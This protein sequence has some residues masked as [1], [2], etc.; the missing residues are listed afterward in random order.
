LSNSSQK[1]LG[2]LTVTCLVVGGM[3]G[4]G[5][6]TL[7]SALAQ[8]GG[9][10]LTGW[11]IAAAGAL[12]LAKMFGQLSK[13]IP[14]TGGAY[15]YSREAFGEF[16]GFIV[17][18]GYWLS[19]WST[20]AAIS[21]TFTGYLSIFIPQVGEGINTALTSIGVIWILT[22]IN[23]R[24]IY[25]G[26]KTQVLTTVLKI[27]PILVVAFA[28][29]LFFQP[30]HFSP[31]N[32]SQSSDIKAITTASALCLFAFM[33]LEAASVPAGHIK[34][35]ETTISKAT[36]LGTSIVVVIYIFSTI[37]LF[38]ILP[39]TEVQNSLAPFS[40]AAQKMFGHGAEYFLA[41]GACISTFG[42]LNTW[43]LVQGQMPMALAQDKLLPKVFSK[44]NKND[45]PAFGI[46]ISSLFITLLLIMN[47]SK[48]FSSMYSFMVLLTA[49]TV[50][51]SYLATAAA[52]TYFSVK[53]IH[54]FKLS[55]KTGL[56]SIVGI[57]FSIW[58]IIGSG[59]EAI[60]WGAVGLLL[61]IPIYI[62]KKR[63][64]K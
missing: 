60:L 51:V 18:W 54:G 13:V 43:I 35:P 7:P 53:G 15:P 32:L 9:I 37:S 38:G 39:P 61:G 63:Q 6:F 31:F 48:N 30:E 55:I 23:S 28:G 50:L 45:T 36:M 57:G 27:I 33:G 22:A 25:L 52:Y 16:T 4:S 5:I 20:N 62:W 40:D 46:I 58:M 56:F 19:I 24:S 8:F 11:V 3:I 17:A 42:G 21:L 2:L 59:L 29:I 26:G 41:A 10:G 64:A 44:K 49:V 1:P 47:Q 12:V 34:N 14:K